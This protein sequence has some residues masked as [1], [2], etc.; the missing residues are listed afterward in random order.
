MN[1]CATMRLRVR[2]LMTSTSRC[3]RLA[4]GNVAQQIF[5]YTAFTADMVKPQSEGNNT[6][7]EAEGTPLWRMAP[8]PA[9]PLL[10]RRPE[11]WLSGRGFVDLPEIHPSDRAQAAWLYAQFVTSKTVDVKKSHVGLTF[12]RDSSVNHAELHRA[13][14][15]W[16]VWSNSTVRLIAWRGRRPAS[17]FRIIRSWPRSGGSKSV[18]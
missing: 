10:G 18:T 13:R 15:N 11:G 2:R 3:Q 4:Q 9:W 6:V 17:T 1:G 8:K 7:D 16:A 14:P 5:W 12:I